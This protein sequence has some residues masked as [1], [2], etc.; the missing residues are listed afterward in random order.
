MNQLDQERESAREG[1]RQKK[2]REDIILCNAGRRSLPPA[3]ARFFPESPGLE[4]K[5]PLHAVSA[6]KVSFLYR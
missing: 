6:H 1:G 3:Q 2:E 4:V 5:W